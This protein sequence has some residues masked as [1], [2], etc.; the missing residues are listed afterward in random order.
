MK[1][2][3]IG[4]FNKNTKLVD[5]QAFLQKLDLKL[6]YQTQSGRDCHGNPYHYVVTS[7]PDDADIDQIINQYDQIICHGS[8]LIF[9]QYNDR[10]P[11]PEEWTKE[12]KRINT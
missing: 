7:L 5:I 11:C 2:L 12:E 10:I 9:R 8:P 1:K 4:N 3:F 6:E